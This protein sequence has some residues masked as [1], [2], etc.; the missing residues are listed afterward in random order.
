MIR[1]TKT[2][3]ASAALEG[4]TMSNKKPKLRVVGSNKKSNGT[5]KKSATSKNTGLTDK[6]EAFAMAIFE[7]NNFSD[8]YRLAYDASG[9]SNAS[10]NVE[11]CKLVKNPN[12]TLTL[13]RLEEDRALNNRMQRLSRSDRVIQKLEDIAL[14]DGEAD[15]TQVRA[16]ELLGKSMGMWIERVETEDKTERDAESIKAELQARLDRLLG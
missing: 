10:V 5:R 15:G 13:N 3:K 9:M 1:F 4:G 6:Q 7:G 2:P 8:A 11:A 12:V 16:L 14:R